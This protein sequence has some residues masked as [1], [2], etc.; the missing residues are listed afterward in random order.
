MLASGKNP[1]YFF[2]NYLLFLQTFIFFILYVY[3][4]LK[5]KKDKTDKIGLIS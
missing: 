3:I 2:Q 1:K 5:I 4:F